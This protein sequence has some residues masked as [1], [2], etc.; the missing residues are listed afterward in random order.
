MRC[1]LILMA[2]RDQRELLVRILLLHNLGFYHSHNLITGGLQTY[3]ISNR[4]GFY[5]SG[6]I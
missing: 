3:S 5:G 2:D 6:L 1:L 4:N